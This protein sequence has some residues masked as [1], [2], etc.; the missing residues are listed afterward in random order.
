[1]YLTTRSNLS[2]SWAGTP[3]FGKPAKAAGAI[4][5]RN[6]TGRI[7]LVKRRGGGGGEARGRLRDLVFR[8]PSKFKA[9]ELFHRRP[10]S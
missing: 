9:G 3:Y 6:L 1:M 7:Q 8:D 2:A 10:V 4:T 5:A